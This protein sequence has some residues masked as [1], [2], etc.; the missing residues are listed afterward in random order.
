MQS[1]TKKG[2]KTE[3]NRSVG[4]KNVQTEGF[5]LLF[6]SAGVFMLMCE[7]LNNTTG[8]Y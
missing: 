2:R 1:D 3:L 8:G 5:F 6:T 4:N 7:V